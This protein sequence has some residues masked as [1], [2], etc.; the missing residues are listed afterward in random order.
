MYSRSKIIS[1]SVQSNK[2]VLEI[3]CFIKV[4]YLTQGGQEIIYTIVKK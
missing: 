2:A 1:M 4:L 3:I